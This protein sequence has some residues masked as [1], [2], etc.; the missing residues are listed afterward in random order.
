MIRTLLACLLLST[1]VAGIA[2]AETPA[3]P[4][5]EPAPSSAGTPAWKFPAADRVIALGDL[6]GDL[7]ATRAALRLAGL[8]DD[9][10]AWVGGETVLVQ[11]GDQLDRGDDEKEIIDLLEALRPQ[12]E[13]AGGRVVVL[14][15]NHELMNAHGDLRYVTAGGFADFA[16]YGPAKTDD[17]ALAR[18]PEA[19]RGRA[20]A[21]RPGGPY[22]LILAQRP[23]IAQVGDTIFV[24]GG[25]LPHHAK[26][27]IEHYN[28]AYAKWLR[29]EGP[30]HASLRS[31]DTPQWIR[32][33]S[34][35]PDA[36]DCG[37]LADTLDMLQAKRMVVG[38]TVQKGGASSACDGKVWRIDVGMSAH[39]GGMPAAL[40]I[41]GD[42]VDVLTAR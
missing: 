39:Y 17:P 14:N 37:L 12:A 19:L 28:A 30:L 8:I 7:T 35:D 11:T 15:G 21:F 2:C 42:A 32:H 27:G 4:S 22:A 25:I 6:H 26:N 40:E 13:A 38:H 9:K 34:D 31:A 18:L 20:V 23:L 41:K 33:Y 1:G 3:K 29:G 16:Q 5:P 24:H 10:D 36:S